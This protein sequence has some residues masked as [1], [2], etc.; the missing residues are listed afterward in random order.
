MLIHA[1]FMP[2]PFCFI[3]IIA[4][5][6]AGR[7][8]FAGSDFSYGDVMV[9]DRAVL[10]LDKDVEDTQLSHY[11]YEAAEG[12]AFLSMGDGSLFNHH[13]P[14]T[15]DNYWRSEAP[16]DD[17]KSPD[18]FTSSVLYYADKDVQSGE[19]IF[20]SYGDESWFEGRDIEFVSGDIEEGLLSLS[21]SLTDLERT[22]HCLSDVEILESSMGAGAGDGLFATRPFKS[23]EVVS[24]SPVLF[25]AKHTLLET[26]ATSELVNYA[27]S[28]PGSDVSLVPMGRAGMAND[29]GPAASLRLHWYDWASRSVLYGS[30]MPDAIKG[31]TVDEIESSR[32]VTL[33]VCYVATRDIEEGEELTLFYGEEWG[34]EWQLHTQR[35]QADSSALFRHFIDVSPEMFPNSWMIDCV[36][37]S[38]HKK[39]SPPPLANAAE[40]GTYRDD[41]SL[42]MAASTIAGVFAV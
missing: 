22:G 16:S 8:V 39:V 11:F 4:A 3:D 23:G 20:N 29:G 2:P 6:G 13:T 42:Y 30:D 37:N 18:Y 14:I 35:Q 12:R 33:D 21:R 17:P 15:V 19:E 41:C 27:L 31:K 36:G 7:G 34:R 38:C 10:V 9:A 26:S 5:T 1:L 40:V 32:F 25:M 28:L 24:L